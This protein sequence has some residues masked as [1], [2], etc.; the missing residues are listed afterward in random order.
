MKE[1][2]GDDLPYELGISYEDFLE[3]KSEWILWRSLGAYN[4]DNV[5]V[6]PVSFVEAENMP[7]RKL[8]AFLILDDL[9]ELMRKQLVRKKSKAN[10]R[11][12]VYG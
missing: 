3:Y 4:Q 11:Q 1:E 7:K 5:W 2:K 8:D 10:G 12:K 6:A 9:L